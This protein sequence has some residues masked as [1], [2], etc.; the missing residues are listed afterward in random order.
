VSALTRSVGH[1][2]SPRERC[3]SRPVEIFLSRVV[4]ADFTILSAVVV[5]GYP[6]AQEKN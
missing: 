4:G 5:L 2:S 3:L 6:R 1:V